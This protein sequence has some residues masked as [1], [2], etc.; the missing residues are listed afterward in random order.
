MNI[1]FGCDF[2]NENIYFV[3]GCYGKNIHITQVRIENKHLPLLF[4]LQQKVL[5]ITQGRGCV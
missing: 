1:F 4:P 2:F 5:K 3:F